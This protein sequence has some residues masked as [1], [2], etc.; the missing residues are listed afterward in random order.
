LMDL[1]VQ[2]ARKPFE[3]LPSSPSWKT[4]RIAAVVGY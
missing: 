4:P 3:W 1:G 2:K